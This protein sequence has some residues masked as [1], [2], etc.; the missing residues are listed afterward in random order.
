[1]TTTTALT[2]EQQRVLDAIPTS[3]GRAA[4]IGRI[5]EA[6]GVSRDYRSER[7]TRDVIRS[8]RLRGHPIASCDF[9]YFLAECAEDL[10]RTRAQL[11]SRVKGIVE[12]CDAIERTRKREFVKEGRLF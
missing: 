7:K 8:L 10:E 6:A 12:V 5:A 2:P 9:G 4:T 3:R 1:M 11:Y